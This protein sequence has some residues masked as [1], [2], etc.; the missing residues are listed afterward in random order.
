VDDANIVAS[1]LPLGTRYDAENDK[2]AINQNEIEGDRRMEPDLRT[3]TIIQEVANTIWP[4][5]QWTM[6]V[7]SNH[8]H[9]MMPMLDTQVGVRGNQVYFEF[10]E[11][12]VN[13]PY[14]IPERSAHS[15]R[16][17]RSSLVQEGVRR[18]LNTSRNT[19]ALT[20]KDIMERWDK[21]LRYSGYKSRFR[22]QV[23][24]T[25]LGIYKDKVKEDAK[26]GGKPLYRT[27][28]WRREARDK[29]KELKSTEWYKGQGA[30]TNIAPLIIDPTEGGIM[31]DEMQKICEQFRETH[32]MGILVQ[33]RGGSKSSADVKSDPLGT[34]LCQRTNCPICRTEGSRGGCQGGNIGYQHQCMLCD[35]DKDD[36]G[37]GTLTLYY[38]ES[39]KSGYERGLQHADGLLKKKEDNVMHKHMMIHHKD[40]EPEFV[41]TVTGRF[42][43]CLV[44]QED[45][46]TRLSENDAK[47]IMNSKM[48]WHQPAINRVVVVR[49]NANEDQAGAPQPEP[50]ARGAPGPGRGRRGRGR[51]G[52]RTIGTQ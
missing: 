29:E 46:G 16:I 15:W 51:G 13:T 1:V 49:G 30:V 38:G 45:E 37:Q 36:R 52:A 27:R 4:E 41:M 25:A 20:R 32:K 11:K 39:S 42:R 6:D 44:R 35:K 12:A 19:S 3:F 21:K 48:Q 47:I 22:E 24:S 14:C 40:M 43:S 33:E 18:M 8:T 9:G 34:K 28:E 2:L 7:P 23:I 5:I 31:K 26:E 10:Y 50:D 17:K